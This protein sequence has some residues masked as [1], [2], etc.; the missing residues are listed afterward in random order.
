MQWTGE[1]KNEYGSV[2]VISDAR[3]G[4]ITGTF[5]T[6]LGDSGFAGQEFEI[7]G[8]YQGPCIH[9]AFARKGATGDT[10]ASFTGLMRDGK[11]KTVWHVVADRALK[12]P[13]PGKPPEN[14]ELPWA[15]A[16]QT[17]SDTFER[18]RR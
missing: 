5:R 17:N 4:R 1:W 16:V 13:E 8:L 6:A 10:I 11:M 2:L 14:I 7:V 3:E 9:F 18:V 12:S 15:H